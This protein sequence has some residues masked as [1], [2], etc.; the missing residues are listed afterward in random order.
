MKSTILELETI[1][2]RKIRLSKSISR[3]LLQNSML[4]MIET[5]NDLNQQILGL[6]SNP[7]IR[8]SIKDKIHNPV[9]QRNLLILLY[10]KPGSDKTGE[11]N[12]AG[13]LP[14]IAYQKK[15]LGQLKR[16]GTKN[17]V[18]DRI[19]LAKADLIRLMKAEYS[20]FKDFK[21]D[22]VALFQEKLLLNVVGFGEISTVLRM[23]GG[24]SYSESVSD[25]DSW[26]YKKM[27]VFPSEQ[28]VDEFISIFEEYRRLFVDD[29]GVNIPKQK[30]QV[31]KISSE[32]IRLYVLQER[33]NHEF[34]GHKLIQRFSED[35]GA[36][37]FTMILK[38]LKKVWSFN[39][40]Q[41]RIKIA[42]D[43]QISNWVL[44]GFRP[45]ENR[46]SGSEKLVYIDTSS[47]LFRVAGKEQLDP[48]LF[49]KS[50]PFFLR[51]I[52]RGLFLQEVLDRYYDLH[53]VTV[54]LIA[55]FY[56][57]GRAE[58]IPRMI[59]TA[60]KFFQKHMS[61]FNIE[62]ITVQ[63]VEKYYKSDAFIWKFY[64][65]ARK[66]DRFIT[67]KVLRG[68]YEFRLPEKVKR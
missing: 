65:A 19:A 20:L 55:N 39:A 37:F 67:E 46:F 66:V 33:F 5:V 35:E 4:K 51:P 29:I 64:L 62:P 23:A 41:Q 38:E 59:E 45:G 24:R 12:E 27:P 53:L 18:D 16:E 14:I 3:N 15:L 58:Y 49:L 44:E 17:S 25:R 30:T 13:I 61:S 1:Y 2:Q 52:I 68:K 10:G 22:F 56:K 42:I 63:E 40:A 9:A 32:K 34:V 60:N 54:D 50:T 21:R 7:E 43:A 57:E 28:K 26:V 31:H 47:P 36:A 6:I 11:A 8:Q 48:E